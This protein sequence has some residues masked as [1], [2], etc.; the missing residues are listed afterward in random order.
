MKFWRT[1]VHFLEGFI[2]IALYVPWHTSVEV[3]L[4]HIWWISIGLRVLR[5]QFM[6]RDKKART[7]SRPDTG[8]QKPVTKDLSWQMTIYFSLKFEH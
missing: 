8:K 6:L 3:D 4:K 2:E 5:N 1:Y 7:D